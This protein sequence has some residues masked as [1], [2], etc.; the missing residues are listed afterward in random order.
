MNK[1]VKGK[2]YICL[3]GAEGRVVVEYIEP[4][5]PNQSKV[6]YQGKDY[7]IYNDSIL[8]EA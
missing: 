8:K 1:F 4:R 3:W 7:F 5:G 2:L 6:R